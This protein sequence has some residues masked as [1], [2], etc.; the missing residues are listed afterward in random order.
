VTYQGEACNA[1]SVIVGPTKR[2]TDMLVENIGE[3]GQRFI[4]SE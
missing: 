1:A 4:E 2:R 3:W